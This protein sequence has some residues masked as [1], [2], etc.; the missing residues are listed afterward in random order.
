MTQ[1]TKEKYLACAFISKSY[2][3]IYGRIIE[4]LDNDY[5]KVK[6]NTPRIW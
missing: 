5:T 6:K 3:K 4:E 1:K 2:R